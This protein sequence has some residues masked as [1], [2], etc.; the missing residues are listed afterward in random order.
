MG[1][2]GW[3]VGGRASR[4]AHSDACPLLPPPPPPCPTTEAA[5]YPWALRPS[6]HLHWEGVPGRDS[7]ELLPVRA[8]RL[9]DACNTPCSLARC[10]AEAVAR[11]TAGDVSVAVTFCFNVRHEVASIQS[12][13]YLKLQPD[14][15]AVSQLWRGRWGEYERFE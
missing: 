15:S 10:P 8:R 1:G 12:T 7:G 13:D 6:Q 14:G 11:V 5:A 4:G 2:W 3:L 9:H